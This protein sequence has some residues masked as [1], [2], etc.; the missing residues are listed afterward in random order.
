MAGGAVAR[1]IA[2]AMIGLMMISCDESRLPSQA[3]TLQVTT[4][5]MPA[6]TRQ[7]EAS[8]ALTGSGVGGFRRISAWDQPVSL[9]ATAWNLCIRDAYGIATPYLSPPLATAQLLAKLA[10]TSDRSF[11]P[12]QR[13]WLVANSLKWLHEPVPSAD[14][15]K[16]VV[17]SR[18]GD[19][20]TYMSNET[21]SWAAAATAV[22]IFQV[23]GIA[24]PSF[25][26][27]K[28][29]VDLRAITEAATDDNFLV[30]VVP[31][32]AV[33]DSLVPLS[34]RRPFLAL[35][36]TLLDRQ[37]A[38]IGPAPAGPS[39]AVLGKIY[40]IAEANG[41]DLAAR[42]IVS[43]TPLA[44][45]QG[46]L[47]LF[48]DRTSPDP[49]VTC[50]AAK[51][52]FG[53]SVQLTDAVARTAGPAG[54]TQWSVNPPDPESSLYALLSLRGLGL[55]WNEEA[56]KNQVTLWTANISNQVDRPT[57]GLLSNWFYVLALAHELEFPRP[58]WIESR[59]SALIVTSD[60]QL[61]PWLVALAAL[62]GL[63]VLSSSPGHPGPGG[64]PKTMAE[65]WV[66]ELAASIF[67]EPVLADRAKQAAADL[68]VSTAAYRRSTSTSTPDLLS[69]AAGLQLEQA[70]HAE[71]TH[72]VA[73]FGSPPRFSIWPVDTGPGN[74]S[75]PE[76]L[77]LGLL[78][79]G[80]LSDVTGLVLATVS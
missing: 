53:P 14:L 75:D 11:P 68:R 65:A 21:P 22:E 48:D 15:Q 73:V 1:G 41:I 43:L 56:L 18:A 46:Y 47:S 5:A 54:W 6:I 70:D 77:Y 20:Y 2:V 55:H 4:A 7:L 26:A 9:Y 25:I 8:W 31:L 12:L 52:G 50:A 80:S 13:A 37:L 40:E 61:Q 42:E 27:A 29:E 66:A 71:R 17:A 63:K 76:A 19:L 45:P 24:P 16:I 3:P 69:T 59:V 44:T 28:A 78:A 32:W 51:L 34:E 39:I 64:L 57:R 58:D 36:R 38:R 33:A 62:M 35:L 10:D 60:P 74:V 67:D 30:S 72:V 79:S 23:A 49:Q